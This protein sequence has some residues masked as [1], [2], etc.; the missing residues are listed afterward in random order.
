LTNLVTFEQE[1]PDADVLVVTSAWPRPGNPA[2]GIFIKRE[3]EALKRLGVKAD[4]M[5]I[6]G[7]ASSLAYGAAPLDVA[8]ALRGGRYRIVHAYG[9]EA[10]LAASV[11]WRRGVVATYLG[12]DLLGSPRG[13][14]RMALSWR[15]RRQAVRTASRLMRRTITR[16]AEMENVLPRPARETNSVVPAGV[17]EDVFKPLAR[18]DARAALG[19]PDQELVAL[20]AADPAVP[21]KRHWLA[22][23]ATEKARRQFPGLRLHILAGTPP[24][25]VW[26]TMNAADCLLFTS[27]HEGSPN[28]VKEAVMCNLPV[29]TTRVGDV[30]ETLRGVVPSWVCDDDPTELGSALDA[31]LTARAR[32]NGRA[33]AGRLTARNI[34]ERVIAVYED[35]LDAPLTR[36]ASI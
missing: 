24:Q 17:D 27:S 8:R 26:L 2:S 35:A 6:R 22:A 9:G 20:F 34:A 14:G 15:V 19:W 28:V 23:E 25:D 31:C 3:Q 18:S 12:S 21:R 5:A 33:Q 36:G 11:A 32:S 1:T 13:D 10:A 16:T 4:V 29:V 30:E 7:Y